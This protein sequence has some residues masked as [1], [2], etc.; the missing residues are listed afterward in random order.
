M[1][2]RQTAARGVLVSPQCRR[3]EA[4]AAVAA[5]TSCGRPSGQ[6]LRKVG[7]RSKQSL[8]RTAW[9]HFPPSPTHETSLL[10]SVM[11]DSMKLACLLVQPYKLLRLVQGQIVLLLGPL[12]RMPASAFPVSWQIRAQQ[13]RRVVLSD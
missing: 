11:S 9:V 4:F 1:Y 6:G 7:G 12:L 8:T 10:C 3:A 2:R 13:A 5:G